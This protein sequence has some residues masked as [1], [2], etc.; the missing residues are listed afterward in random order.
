LPKDEGTVPL[1]RLIKKNASD[2]ITRDGNLC[3]SS[4]PEY[5]LDEFLFQERYIEF[6]IDG[7]NSA[8]TKLCSKEG[9][10]GLMAKLTPCNREDGSL[11]N[12]QF[13]VDPDDYPGH[14]HYCGNLFSVENV[15]FVL[16]CFRLPQNRW[17]Y[18]PVS[19]SGKPE[20]SIDKSVWRWGANCFTDSSE[21]LT[22]KF[23]PRHFRRHWLLG[24]GVKIKPELFIKLND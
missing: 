15:F 13:M 23:E 4:H 5:N 22:G 3:L 16:K 10:C 11:F 14:L 9:R 1:L 8:A 17:R 24:R 21:K 19:W 7:Q 20:C 6:T 18:F 12:V 2:L